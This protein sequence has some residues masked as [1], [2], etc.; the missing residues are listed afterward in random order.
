MDVVTLDTREQHTY[1][2][3]K[4]DDFPTNIYNHFPIVLN[5][6]G[7]LWVEANM[8]LLDKLKSVKHVPSK[9]LESKACDLVMYKRWLDA[10]D[11]DYL[12]FPKR[13]MARPT[14]RYCAHLHEQINC[15]SI[16]HSTAKRR[17]GTVQTFYR[18]LKDIRGFVFDNPPW[19]EKEVFISFKDNK[20]FNLS[21]KQTTTDLAF[22]QANNNHNYSE[23]IQDGGSLRPLPKE[24]QHELMASIITNM[25][26]RAPFDIIGNTGMSKPMNRGRLQ[27]FGVHDHTINFQPKHGFI[28][29]LLNN[30]AHVTCTGDTTSSFLF[31]Q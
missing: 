7:S 3:R 26:L 5:A 27:V 31:W 9:T 23:Y 11:I 30:G 8:F 16:K 29:T 19:R 14:Y 24:E 25:L 13:I 17:M 18:W 2:Y 22:R 12:N 21:K 10:E 4:S 15:A 1:K 6:A 20:G 28:E